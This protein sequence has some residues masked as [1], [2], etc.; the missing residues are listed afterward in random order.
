MP[1]ENTAVVEWEFMD[2]AIDLVPAASCGLVE[3]R[4]IKNIG[5]IKKNLKKNHPDSMNNSE[6]LI[7]F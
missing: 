6:E 7:F 5:K 2:W 4:D 1:H 3:A